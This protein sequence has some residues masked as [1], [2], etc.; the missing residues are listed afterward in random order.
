MREQQPMTQTMKI[1]DVRGHLNTLVNRVFRKETRV[2]V[3]KSG[4]PVTAI[5]PT[6]DLERLNR[7]DQERAVCFGVI[8]ELQE[9]FVGVPA[10][11]IKRGLQRFGC[12]WRAA[13]RAPSPKPTYLR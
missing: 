6:E 12:R 3:E 9:A 10:E 2:V 13:H 4:I 5:I 7:L 1:S 8:D 11:E